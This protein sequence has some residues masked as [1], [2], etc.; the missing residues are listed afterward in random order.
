MI[1]SRLVAA[2]LA[3][4][5]VTAALSFHRNFADRKQALHFIQNF[6]TGGALLWPVTTEGWIS[7]LRC[8]PPTVC[9]TRRY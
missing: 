3:I 7:Q 4:I 9:V 1:R 2:V 5:A 8:T 6:A